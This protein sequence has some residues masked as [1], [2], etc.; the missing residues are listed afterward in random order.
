MYMYIKRTITIVAGNLSKKQLLGKDKHLNLR[1][2]I[3]YTC[4]PKL[5]INILVHALAAINTDTNMEV[6]VQ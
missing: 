4:M 5:N 1:V 3:L 6:T 2:Y